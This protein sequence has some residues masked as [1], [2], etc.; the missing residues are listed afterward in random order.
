MGP[1]I[2]PGMLNALK[3]EQDR[4]RKR[5]MLIAG[6]IAVWYFFLK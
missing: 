2:T 5:L 3:A 4:R 1:I 6:A